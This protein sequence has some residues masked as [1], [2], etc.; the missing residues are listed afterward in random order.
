MK[1]HIKTKEVTM[2]IENLAPRE[3]EV[4]TLFTEEGLSVKEMSSR[5]FISTH[6]VKIYLQRIF[7]KFD[8]HSRYE[9]LALIIRDL[10]SQL[11]EQ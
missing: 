3:I 11:A 2:N 7:E 6:T 9:L 8:V 4:L 10:K 5:L 1:L